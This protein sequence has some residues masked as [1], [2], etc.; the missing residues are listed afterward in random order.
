MCAIVKVIIEKAAI[1]NLYSIYY[2]TYYGSTVYA[3]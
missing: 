2:I 1:V 3:V